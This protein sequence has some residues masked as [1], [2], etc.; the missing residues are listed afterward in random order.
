MSAAPPVDYSITQN[1]PVANHVYKFLKTRCGSDHIKATR[2]DTFGSLALS[3]LGKIADVKPQKTEFTKVFKVTI[4]EDSYIRQGLHLTSANAQ[5][6][7][8]QVDRMFREELFFHLIINKG[9]SDKMFM[10]SIRRFMEVYEI[11][12]EDIKLDTLYRDFKRRKKKY[13]KTLSI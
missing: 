1:I 9:L 7:N 5:V 6:F 10:N 2:T 4:A 13:E 8:H 11:T 12:E 3:L